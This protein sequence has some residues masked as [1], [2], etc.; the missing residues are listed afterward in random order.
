MTGA[1]EKER[2]FWKNYFFHCAFI[3]YQKGLSLEEIWSSKPKAIIT[4]NTE[5]NSSGMNTNERNMTDIIDNIDDDDSV[6][7]DFEE[8][9]LNVENDGAVTRNNS[10]NETSQS[11]PDV[12]AALTKSKSNDGSGIGEENSTVANERT[13]S[14]SVSEYEIVN[15]AIGNIND[16]D[17]GDDLD[18]MDDMDN[19]DDLEAEIA[20]E[21][22]EE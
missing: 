13:Q 19:M 12:T 10:N 5:I 11:F 6:E 7:L 16:G 17:D 20:R 22:G 14:D 2:L 21:L 3:R 15:D 8:E 9:N 18:D 1:G 4:G